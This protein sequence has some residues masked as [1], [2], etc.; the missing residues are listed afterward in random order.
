M[1]SLDAS[2][3]EMISRCL[4]PDGKPASMPSQVRLDRF[5]SLLAHA[6]ER[7]GFGIAF[8]LRNGVTVPASG[9]AK[10][11][12]VRI[13][14]EGVVA[15]L[16]RKPNLDTLVNLWVTGR[17]DILNGTIFDLAAERPKVRTKAFVKSLD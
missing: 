1:T 8:V 17:V 3:N 16:L 12:A 9:H 13:A 6:R 11:L 5:A 2:K 4:S 14:D 7:L 15:A 10:A